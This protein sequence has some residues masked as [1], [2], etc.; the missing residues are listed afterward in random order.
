MNSI[1]LD[2][3]AP[4]SFPVDFDVLKADLRIGGSEL[5]FALREQY[6]PA[7]VSW[8]EGIMRRSLIKREHRWVISDFPRGA[9]QTLWLPRGVVQSVTKIDY[10]QNGSTLTLTGPTS[11]VT[12]PVSPVEYQEHLA[13][14]AGRVAPLRGETWPSADLDDLTPVTVT[15]QAGWPTFETVPADIR[16]VITAHVYES[17]ENNG[18]LTL[19]T[20]FDKDFVAKLATGWRTVV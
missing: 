17:L 20:G 1:T 6:I 8:C 14:H 13:G 9:E 19:R 10:R 15:Y 11:P 5:D 3:D 7:A 16:R 18:L 12:S 2:I 4:P